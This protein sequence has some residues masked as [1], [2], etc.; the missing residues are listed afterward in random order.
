MLVCTDSFPEEIVFSWSIF[1]FW[2]V[3][4]WGL[5]RR[6]K[7]KGLVPWKMSTGFLVLWTSWVVVGHLSPTSHFWLFRYYLQ[8]IYTEIYVKW[9][10]I[11]KSK[12]LL[13]FAIGVFDLFFIYFFSFDF[14]LSQR[15]PIGLLSNHRGINKHGCLIWFLSF[16]FDDTIMCSQP[17]FTWSQ[18]I[19]RS[20]F[21]YFPPILKANAF[22]SFFLWWL[23]HPVTTGL[24]NHEE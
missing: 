15:F 6:L 16:F 14:N 23:P 1:S 3:R 22:V 11:Y 2:G 17:V 8:H 18:L 7:R 20:D 19:W 10:V 9:M 5:A 13:F 12:C 4:W 21:I 24:C